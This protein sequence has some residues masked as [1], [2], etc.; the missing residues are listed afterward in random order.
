MKF[1]ILFSII[2]FFQHSYAGIIGDVKVTGKLVSY[3]KKTATL[4]LQNGKK[5]LKV[6]RK[7]IQS[8]KKLKT[9]QMVTAS[10]E[11]SEIM[12][13]IEKESKTPSK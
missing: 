12:D 4:S 13:L 6:P 11:A 10:F 5:K 7:S 1:L 3:N 9:G 2:F 8:N